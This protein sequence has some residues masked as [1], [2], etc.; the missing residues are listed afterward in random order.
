MANKMAEFRENS[1]FSGKI[2]LKLL[3]GVPEEISKLWGG[4]GILE[5]FEIRGGYFGYTPPLAHPWAKSSKI[6]NI[7]FTSF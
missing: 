3:G 6:K 4:G 7:A 2:W 5:I 1:P